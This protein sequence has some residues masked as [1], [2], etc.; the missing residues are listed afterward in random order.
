MKALFGFLY[1]IFF[2]KEQIIY[3]NQCI[4]AFN[5]SQI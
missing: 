2:L 3:T 4:V 5:H 1:F